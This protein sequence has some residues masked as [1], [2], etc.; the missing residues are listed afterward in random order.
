MKTLVVVAPAWCDFMF[1]LEHH[2]LD[3]A[4]G[5]TGAHRK[6]R[7]ART[8]H[9]GGCHH[10]HDAETNRA[11]RGRAAENEAS[12]WPSNPTANLR[13]VSDPCSGTERLENRVPVGPI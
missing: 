9:E 8:D 2:V 12:H 7:G 10:C 5:Q 1:P 4:L 6:P 3:R 11:R 13:T